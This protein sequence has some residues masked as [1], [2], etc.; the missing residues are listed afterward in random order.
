MNY[1]K[2]WPNILTGLRFALIPLLMVLLSLEQTT[3]LAFWAWFVFVFAAV[4]DWLDGYLARKFDC[5]TVIGKLMDPLADKLLVTAALLMLIPMGRIAAWVCLLVIARE[6]F[7]TG[8]RGLAA[9]KNK[10]VAA[11]NLGKIKANFQYYG[12]GFLI[13][14]VGLL[15][16]PYQLEF[17][18][19]LIWIS[20]VM[21][22]WSAAQYMYNLRDIFV[23]ES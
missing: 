11:D 14:P 23:E 16:I 21:S 18:T 22:Y 12:I 1:R 6:I 7:I 20:I 17:G 2:F 9:S 15:P 5:E 3:W 10:V 8:V 19:V 4:T 13:F